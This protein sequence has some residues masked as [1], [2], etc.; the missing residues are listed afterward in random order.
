[1]DDLG[2]GDEAPFAAKVIAATSLSL[3]IAVIWVGR[4]IPWG[5]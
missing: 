3:W 4:L 1:V 2:P 5:L